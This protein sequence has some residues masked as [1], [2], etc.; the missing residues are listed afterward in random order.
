LELLDDYAKKNK[1]SEVMVRC[2]EKKQKIKDVFSPSQMITVI[3]KKLAELSFD[4]EAT[5]LNDKKSLFS[6]YLLW[7]LAQVK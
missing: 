4:P 1:Q 6:Y 3:V 2:Q 7:G 5:P